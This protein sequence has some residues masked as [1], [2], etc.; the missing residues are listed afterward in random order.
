M[1]LSWALMESP[2]GQLVVCASDQGLVSLQFLRV[3]TLEAALA[4]L[5]ARFGNPVVA[6][7]RP[8]MQRARRQ[9]DAWFGGKRRA[10][11]LPLDLRGTPFQRRVWAALQQIPFG[12]TET[13]AS[14]AAAIGQTSAVRA[15]ARACG[16]NPLPILVPCHRV[17]A[18]D[19]ALTGYLGG[20]ETKR[21]LL[22]LE[23][24]EP[25][26][27]PLFAVASRRE[28]E[29]RR[30][31]ETEQ[32]ESHLPPE[33]AAWLERRS[34]AN[35]GAPAW[36]PEA[37]LA[38]ALDAVGAPGTPA[39]AA[40]VAER[41]LQT[42]D[43]GLRA[44]ADD[45]LALAVARMGEAPPSGGDVR[46]LLHAALTLDSPW[47][48]VLAHRLIGDRRLPAPARA[49][50]ERHLEAILDG[51]LPCP[52][53]ARERAVDLWSALRHAAGDESWYAEQADDPSE[54]FAR[55]GLYAETIAFAEER[56]A[57]GEGD[58]AVL[59]RRLADAYEATGE[60]ALARQRLLPLVAER[61]R[62][63]DLARLRAIE[64]RLR[65]E[66]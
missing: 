14:L 37:W 48:A 11:A 39:L 41:A 36:S 61:R 27:L 10:F 9:L 58:R 4:E 26:H 8:V 51:S 59:L 24:S 23:R 19:G 46:G 44:L 38:A 18:S 63:D 66:D 62:A 34:G 56:L 53:P 1:T 6:D 30:H 29:T 52:A 42:G 32:L 64:D 5:V 35:V 13:Y 60:L 50:L 33:A 7:E 25:T 22:A 21:R 57:R 65:H 55:A 15:V 31:R 40:L 17:V 49:E 12:E 28:D 3:Q 43:P 45:L 2:V 20:L 47:H 54:L 16:R